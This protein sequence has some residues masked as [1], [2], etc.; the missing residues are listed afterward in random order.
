[1][2]T[3]NVAGLP[4]SRKTPGIY[5]N[6]IL[7]G[8]AT[9][10]GDAPRK[11]VILANKITSSLTGASPSFTVP[12][13]TLAAAT[14]TAVGSPDDVATYAGLGSEAHRMARRVFAQ[15]PEADVTLCLVAESGG[16]KASAVY[17]FATTATAAYTVRFRLNGRQIDVAVSVGDT[18]TVIATN[19]A[20]AVLALPQLPVT[21]QFSAGVL[22]LTAKHPGP[23]GND[24][25]TSAAFVD[26]SGRET[27]ITTSSTASPGATTC[28]L[29]GVT[30]VEGTYFLSGGTTAD[31]ATN[32]LAALASKTYHRYVPAH[33]DATNLDLIDAQLDAMAGVTSQMRQQAVACTPAA[34]GAATT[35]A[36]GRNA[37]RLQLVWHYNS[38]L[39]PEEV[40]AQVCAA[41]LIG[42]GQAGGALDGEA[43]DPAANLDGLLLRD[44]VPQP[45]VAEQPTPIEV[46]SALNNGLTVLVPSA[47]GRCAVARSITTCS[48]IN[49]Q[50]NYSVL[51]TSVPTI[52]DYVADDLQADLAATFK[53]CKLAPDSTDGSPPKQPG[54]ATPSYVKA[55][56]RT[57]L[58]G[59]EQDAAILQNVD[60][61]AALLQVVLDATPGRL[62][63]EIPADPMPGLHILGGNVRQV[64]A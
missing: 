58:K 18:A 36:V 61:H 41:R 8:A 25:V 62:D 26:S 60:A 43:T 6:V 1:M 13:G 38:P 9:S 64:A 24:L 31:D 34:S 55:R 50:P 14:P 4:A 32:A 46:E 59:Y 49:S 3:V 29:S 27:N 28:T 7:G 11:I 52:L 56:I 51:D 16:A 19:C 54:V 42:D 53:G 44:V 21:A 20:A 5:L 63:A 22:T 40:A 47:G 45:N 12:A 57:K 10:A 48:L 33:R 17:T 35:L 15:Y 30:T 23:R 39:A 2:P 37:K